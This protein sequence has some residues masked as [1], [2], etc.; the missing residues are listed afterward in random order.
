MFVHRTG[1]QHLRITMVV[2]RSI[3]FSKFILKGKITYR[4]K[5]IAQWAVYLLC[6]CGGW[7]S[8]CSPRVE[9]T[10]T[11]IPGARWLARQAHLASSKFSERLCLNIEDGEW[12]EDTWCQIL[13]EYTNAYIC[14]QMHTNACML[15]YMRTWIY[16]HVHTITHTYKLMQRHFK[17]NKWITPNWRKISI[18]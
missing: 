18:W 16:T 2:Y 13:H 11:A 7:R 10:E 17:R 14:I 4:T 1:R 9:E 12:R 8:K 15:T 5:E 3:F 6:K